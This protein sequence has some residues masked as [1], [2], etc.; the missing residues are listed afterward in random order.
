MIALC[1]FCCTFAATAQTS[2]RETF[3]MKM[4]TDGRFKRTGDQQFF[5]VNFPGKKASQLY[6]DVLAHLSQCYVYPDRVTDKVQ[7]RSI[8]IN[9]YEDNLMGISGKTGHVDIKYRVEI[10]FKDGRI[11]M[12]LPEIREYIIITPS[13]TLNF[14][15]AQLPHVIAYGVSEALS[16]P[17]QYFKVLYGALAYGL[18][19]DD[20]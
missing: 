5:V 20:W 15:G 18:Q 17:V 16:K 10:Q 11:R 14:E 3:D 19:N 9:G 8:V 7:D 12:N 2:N 6:S 13:A 1:I 4:D